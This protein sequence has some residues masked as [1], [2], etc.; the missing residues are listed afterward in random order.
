MRGHSHDH[1]LEPTLRPRGDRLERDDT[2]LLGRAAAAGRTDVLG[3]AGMLGLQR[4]V[5]NAGTGS[6]VEEERSPVH[7]VVGSGG[8]APLDAATRTD[9]ES[10]FAADFSDVRVHTDGA[11]HDS[12]KSVNAQAYT[13][14]SNIVFQRDKYDPA[15]DS[16][17][18][19]L[20]HELTHVVQ[21]RSGPVDGTDAGGGV[22]VSD[23]SDRFEREAVA[24]ADRLMSAPAPAGPA[25]QRCEDGG[26]A[27][28]DSA[29]VQ[30]E[31]APAAEEGEE[32]KMAQTFVQREEEGEEEA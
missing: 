10:R 8:G 15:S 29:A 16:G 11:A 20:A 7:D 26:H 19:M 18:H 1:D 4:A 23:P 2:D 21:Q 24:N 9:M 22:K 30:R 27:A 5:G 6:L 31:E 32:E 3:P 13:V 28:D 14:G 25:V 12:A 17:K